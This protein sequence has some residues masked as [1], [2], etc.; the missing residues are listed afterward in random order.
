MDSLPIL[1]SRI[2]HDHDGCCPCACAVDWKL[3]DFEDQAVGT[4][5]IFNQYPGVVFM[6]GDIAGSPVQ[7]VQPSL[8]TISGTKALR[9]QRDACELQCAILAMKFTE[10]QHRVKMSTGLAQAST[11]GILA[12]VLRGY[13]DANRTIQVAQS[14]LLIL[15]A[16]PTIIDNPIEVNSS[17]GSIRSVELSIVLPKQ[18]LVPAGK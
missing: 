5:P 1:D 2:R 3:L 4:L 13:S 6:G 9:V 8:G 14:D 12:A 7:I 17:S 10:G 11:S 18:S 15:G 16:M